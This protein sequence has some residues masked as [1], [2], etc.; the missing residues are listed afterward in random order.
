MYSTE[1]FNTCFSPQIVT[2][3]NGR[4]MSVPCGKCAACADSRAQKLTNRI[5]AESSLYPFKYFLTLTYS[6]ETMPRLK[7]NPR[8]NTF[9]PTYTTD[10]YLEHSCDFEQGREV[11]EIASIT[12]DK[13]AQRYGPSF[14]VVSRRDI[15]LFIKRLRYYLSYY[16]CRVL[17][18]QYEK[19]LMTL[20]ALYGFIPVLNSSKPVKNQYI[21]FLD[22]LFD[23]DESL[24][25]DYEK[26]LRILK[27]NY[28]EKKSYKKD[29]IR[30][31]IVSEYSPTLLRPHYHGIIFTSHKEV[32]A[33]L[34]KA[35]FKSWKKCNL[36]S[37]KCEP[38]RKNVANYVAK[39]ITGNYDLPKVL[40]SKPF[41]PFYLCSQSPAFG[42]QS[43]TYEKVQQMY[44]NGV[45]GENKRVY[46][47][48]GIQDAFV[49]VPSY[50]L[51]RFFPL[52]ES[53]GSISDSEK[54]RIYS[55]FTGCRYE[56]IGKGVKSYFD[57]D[58][59]RFYSVRLRCELNMYDKRKYNIAGDSTMLRCAHVSSQ[60][61]A[62]AVACRRWCQKFGCT[63]AHYLRVL[64]WFHYRRSMR[65]L[66]NQYVMLE[67]MIQKNN[68][69]RCSIYIDQSVIKDLPAYLPPAE[70]IK[71]WRVGS[72]FDSL[73]INYEDLYD[74]SGRL[75]LDK[76]KAL[77]EQNDSAY[78][79][80]RSMIHDRYLSSIAKKQHNDTKVIHTCL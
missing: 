10:R 54:L 5:N 44:V 28:N 72:F 41:R 66:A 58:L 57:V 42:Y 55:L 24:Y 79:N 53:Y 76:Q 80:Y 31:F 3:P 12:N 13:Y 29:L 21:E 59:S 71:Y 52:C 46:R 15:Q 47:K 67:N 6:N 30:Y 8:R 18:R 62:A 37:F 69:V 63:P 75:N 16:Y 35:S 32:A 61:L 45:D 60:N 40:R 14:G 33:L 34:P 70:S 23:F 50:V 25:F 51:H 39:Y 2:L 17:T 48:N 73:N 7:Y 49:P 64:D 65:N 1:V 19:D 27:Y 9:N 36:A 43:F 38:V 11:L 74:K 22:D 4:R 56:K 26:S 77:L 20:N 68:S 78:A